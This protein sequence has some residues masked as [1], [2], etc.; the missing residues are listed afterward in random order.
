MQWFLFENHLKNET[1]NNI[2]K[3]GEASILRPQTAVIDDYPN[4]KVRNTNHRSQI[5]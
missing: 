3:N 5:P 2:K 1:R 4:S